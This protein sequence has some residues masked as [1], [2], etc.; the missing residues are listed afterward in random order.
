MGG[1]S[2]LLRAAR[3][4]SLKRDEVV[5]THRLNFA[6][7]CSFQRHLI[8]AVRNQRCGNSEKHRPPVARPFQCKPTFAPDEIAPGGSNLRYIALVV[9]F[10][11]KVE[12]YN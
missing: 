6:A 5:I 12:L 9:F 7:G 1:W 8:F 2:A 4:L 10:S 3:L 11:F